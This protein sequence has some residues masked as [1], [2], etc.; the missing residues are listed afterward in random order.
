M[1]DILTK[2]ANNIPGSFQ[3]ISTENVKVQ[4]LIVDRHNYYRSIVQPTASNMFKMVWNFETARNADQHAKRCLWIHSSPT[5]REITNLTCGENIFFAG[6]L[7]SW[8]LIIEIYNSE[9]ENFLYGEG[10]S[11]DKPVGHYTQLVWDRSF[12]LGCAIAYCPSNNPPV[13]IYVCQYC[14]A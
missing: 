13:Y 7:L 10:A 6:I 3:S 11:S 4:K 12:F 2:K 9:K 8:E 1:C 14:P 5:E